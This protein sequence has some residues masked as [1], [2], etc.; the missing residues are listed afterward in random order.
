MDFFNA[1]EQTKRIVN[2]VCSSTSP[3]EHTRKYYRFRY[4]GQFYGG[5]VTADVIG[6][7]LRCVYCWS[8]KT[9]WHPQKGS[10]YS[11]SQVVKA[12]LNLSRKHNCNQIRLSGGEPT[13]CKAHLLEILQTIP[14]NIL[15]ILETNGI[16][17]SDPAYIK[18]LEKIPNPPYV[19]ISMKAGKTIFSKVTG[20]SL[21]A[22]DL[23]L[24]AIHLLQD[25]DLRFNVA[26]MPDFFTQEEI[27]ELQAFILPKRLETEY[28]I[29]YPF[30]KKKL[31]ER[32]FIEEN[33]A[34][35]DF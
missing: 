27:S 29:M 7:N 34:I 14:G 9:A 11:T 30:I 26:I 35:D 12:L 22:Y 23:Q 24:R 21:E 6:C 19:R 33:N 10:W 18:A 2:K 28:L 31:R 4:A 32:G 20:A 17:L 25:S 13:L 8:Q 1:L 16:L 3:E 5:I 15:F